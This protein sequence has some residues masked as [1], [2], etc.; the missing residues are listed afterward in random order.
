MTTITVEKLDEVYMRVFS[1]AGVEQELSDFFSYDFPGAKFTPKFRARL[2]DGK[3]RLYD[4]VRKTLYI[5]L[6]AYIKEFCVRNGYTLVEKDVFESE[7]RVTEEQVEHFAKWLNPQSRSGPIEFRDYQLNAVKIALDQERTLLL[8]PTASGKSLII[9]S[10]MRWHLQAKRKCIIIVPSTSLVEQLYADFEDYSSANGFVVSDHAQ[11]LYSGFSREMTHDVLITTWQSIYLNPKKW[12]DQFD[13][14]FGDEAHQFKAKSL[15]SVMEKLDEVKF[16]IGTT[17]TLDDE[18][19]HRLVLEGVFGPV[20]RVTTTRKLMDAGQIA[21][22]DI[23]CLVL[24]YSD[25]IRKAR[26]KADYASEMDW[27]V[28]HHPRNKFIRNLAV[29]SN[30]N[31]L[32][33]FQFVAKHGRILERMI[34]ERVAEGRRVFFVHG[35]VGTKDREAVRKITE[36]ENDAIIIASYGTFST[37]INIPS[38]QNVIF[39]SPTRSKIRNLQSIGRGLRNSEGKVTCALYD[40]A[41]DLQWKSWTNHTLKHAA[42][43]YKIYAEEEFDAKIIEVPIE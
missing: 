31:T 1:E 12:F 27:I 34:S 4:V 15:I 7:T 18:K 11:K 5:G 25:E 24:K 33:L 19:I 39:A 17:G 2:W 23:T 26:A 22:L 38:I 37:G 36:T 29:R 3:V 40:I 13:V 43:R 16:R 30:G 20:H 14:V 42:A 10:I 35:D 21:N 41:D 28:S 9:Y 32:V 8:S 6:L